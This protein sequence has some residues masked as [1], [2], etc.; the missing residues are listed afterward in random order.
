MHLQRL[1]PSRLREFD[2]E[3]LAAT[4]QDFSGAEI[5]QAIVDAMYNAF[6]GSGSST[7]RDF[8][9][10]DILQAIRETVPLASIARDQI[11]SLKCWA[12]QAGARTAS[13]DAQVLQE[14]KQCFASS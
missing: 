8:T 14:M 4:A 10:E 9:Q 1:R 7:R 11:E 5:E 2:L 12:A 6:G 13:Q 3:A